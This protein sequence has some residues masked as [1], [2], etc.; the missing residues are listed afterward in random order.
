[1]TSVTS[2][3]EEIVVGLNF[4][5]RHVDRAEITDIAVVLGR[6]LGAGVA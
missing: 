3:E 6:D 5:A 1:M 4:T 2:L